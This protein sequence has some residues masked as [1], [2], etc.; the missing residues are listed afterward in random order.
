[1][2][3]AFEV[4]ADIKT[5]LRTAEVLEGGCPSG[6]EA[7]IIRFTEYVKV[8]WAAILASIETIAPDKRR[9][10]VIASGAEFLGGSDYLTF[11]STLLDKYQANKVKKEV[12]L[13][14]IVAIGK[15]SG[16][17]AYNFQ[18]QIVRNLCVRAKAVFPD[19]AG[20]QTSMTEILSGAQEHQAKLAAFNEG[21]ELELIPS[22]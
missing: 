8:N 14:A 4:P 18:N 13:G 2:I 5:Y 21:R 12:A 20:L 19:E 17:L 16:F 7:Q 15:K 9:Q 22:N 10:R 3:H 6:T 11:L 1:M